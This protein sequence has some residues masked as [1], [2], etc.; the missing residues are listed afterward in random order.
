MDKNDG[1][2]ALIFSARERGVGLG[3]RPHTNTPEP[4]NQAAAVGAPTWP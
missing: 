1:G 3:G 4:Y 2:V